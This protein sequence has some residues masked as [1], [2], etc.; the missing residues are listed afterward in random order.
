[1]TTTAIRATGLTKSFGDHTVLDGIDLEVPAGSVFALLGPNGSGKTTT[2]KILSTLSHPDDGE[3][4]IAGLDPRTDRTEICAQIGLTGQFAAVDTLLTGRENLTMVAR[5]RHLSRTAARE[6]VDRL[7][8]DFDLTEA[9]DRR[10]AEY[11]GGMTR[12]L[13]LAMTLVGEPAIIFLDE[14][15]T[16]LDPRSRRTVWDTVRGLVA[17]GTTIFLTTQYL[18]E[19]D[20]LAD[21]IAVLDR[22]RIVAEGT[23]AELKRLVPGGYIRIDFTDA[24][25]LERARVRF[26]SA[27]D[28]P[29]ENTLAVP[30][31]ADIGAVRD[32]LSTLDEANIDASGIS[33]HTPDLDDVFLTIT[34]RAA[35]T[36]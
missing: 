4:E 23:A 5:L 28:T 29:G 36:N 16:G 24:D 32:V 18:E 35:A 20:H 19:A 21:R 17:G 27:V 30:G 11:S 14:P 1:M 15:T 6:R 9:A 12:R 22:G 2:V 26:P 10:V 7:L 34:G 31:G 13:D 3:V 33:V 8:A 25:D